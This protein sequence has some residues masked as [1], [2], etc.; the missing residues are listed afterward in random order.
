MNG[1]LLID[2]PAG[3]TSR[4]V[5][6]RIRRRVG[7]KVRV[8]HAGTLDPFATGLLPILLGEAT[9]LS[10]HLTGSRKTYLAE[11][12]LGARTDTGDCDGRV[13]EEAPVTTLV[14]EAIR[15]AM[16]G[17][18]G[19]V[20]QRV[21]AF[22]AVK[23]EGRRLHE[24]ARKGD[25]DGIE[26]PERDIVV[27]AWRLAS[28]AADRIVFEVD[29]SAG[30]YVRVLGEQLA[31]ALGTLGHLVALRRLR[32]GNLR[33]EDALRLEQALEADPAALPVVGLEDVLEY[34]T[35]RL[36]AARA[37]L[38]RHGRIIEADPQIPGP[39]VQ[40]RDEDGRLLA[41][42]ERRADPDGVENWKVLRGFH[43]T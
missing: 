12:Y 31:G 35:V 4:D 42:L 21:P 41:L 43:S 16:A 1:V 33:V 11:L 8:G 14:A 9:K 3:M 6:N 34:P 38:V 19:T 2:K 20:R 24:L 13:V 7:R 22:S 17:L 36:E 29:C 26:L 15:E 27:D 32:S 18:T 10:A 28:F 40:A 23:V 37:R 30:T 5:D 39:V 25:L